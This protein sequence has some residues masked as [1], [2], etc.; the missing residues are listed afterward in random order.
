M[1]IGNSRG[2]DD[3]FGVRLA[4]ELKDS[5]VDDVVIAGTQPEMFITTGSIG[6]FDHVV[7]LDAVDFGGSPGDVVFLSCQEMVERFPQVSTHRLSLGLLAK[8]TEQ[9]GVEHAWLLGV[10]PQTLERDEPLSAKLEQT[11]AVLKE[12]LLKRTAKRVHS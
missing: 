9:N 11:F 5:G 1:G 4:E 2:G 3:A 8:W 12:L 6:R 10:Q 7:F